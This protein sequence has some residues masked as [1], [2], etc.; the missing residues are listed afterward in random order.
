MIPIVL[1]CAVYGGS[2][3]CLPVTDMAACERA[4]AGVSM[5]IATKVQCLPAEMITRWVAPMEAP[6]LKWRPL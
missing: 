4:I 6:M 1:A 3:A 2:W 5:D